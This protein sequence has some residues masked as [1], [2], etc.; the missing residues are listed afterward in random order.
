MIENFQLGG[1][2]F[3]LPFHELEPALVGASGKLVKV[4][5]HTRYLTEN[6]HILRC[7]DWVHYD[8]EQCP[9]PELGEFTPGFTAILHDL[10]I[11]PVIKS[12]ADDV[13]LFL[14][15][16][17]LCLGGIVSKIFYYCPLNFFLSD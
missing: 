9:A 11:L 6:V 5:R 10:L 1:K 3:N 2:A 4:I 17:R 8:A 14:F 16:S 7:G 13:H 12:S 15:G